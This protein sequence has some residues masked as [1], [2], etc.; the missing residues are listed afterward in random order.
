MVLNLEKQG[1]IKTAEPDEIYDKIKEILETK[2][3]VK[4]LDDREKIVERLKGLI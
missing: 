3:E 1:Y 2:P 4:R